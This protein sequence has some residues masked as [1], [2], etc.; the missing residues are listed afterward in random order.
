MDNIIRNYL[1]TN[2]IFTYKIKLISL[3]II[4]IFYLLLLFS[5]SNQNLFNYKNLPI[6][7]VK[8]Q[9]NLRNLK[10]SENDILS[11]NP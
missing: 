9:N 7:N 8:Y 6:E 5:S 3:S 10:S 1:V 4:L 2:K 11:I